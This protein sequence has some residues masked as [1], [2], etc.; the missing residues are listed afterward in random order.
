M[1]SKIEGRGWRGWQWEIAKRMH[2]SLEN[3]NAE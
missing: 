1:N 3:V 2:N